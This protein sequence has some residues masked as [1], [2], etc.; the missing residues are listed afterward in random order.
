MPKN[1]Y[2]IL[3]L[4]RQA[5]EQ[6]IKQ[7]YRRLAKQYHPDSN[8]T[9]SHAQFLLINEAYQ[10]LGNAR[11]RR[12]YDRAWLRYQQGGPSVFQA[13][14]P[15]RKKPPS[16]HHP[17]DPLEEDPE[18]LA[19]KYRAAKARQNQKRKEEFL[20]YRPFLHVAFALCLLFSLSMV[21]DWALSH[22]TEIEQLEHGNK[23]ILPT[24][25]QQC[26]ILT[27]TFSFHL[28]CEKADLLGKGDFI[29]LHL[30][31]LYN[32]PIR[33]DVWQSW[34]LARVIDQQAP[35]LTPPSMSFRPRIG[36]YNLFAFFPI[37]L[38]LSSIIGWWVIGNPELS[39]KFGL[40]SVGLI[41][42]NLF[43]IWLS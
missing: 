27:P 14:P 2:Q 11:K 6:D 25:R 38:L 12:E 37:M 8:Q 16:P 42:F 40:L 21:F 30:T 26:S 31:P 35:Q 3:Q 33:L 22:P 15:L 29:S 5:S 1:Y 28:P 23:I 36:I 9:S 4:S 32:I 20:R 13:R 24:G 7:A 39:F 34:P 18:E 43:F 10:I 19:R 41:P 17:A